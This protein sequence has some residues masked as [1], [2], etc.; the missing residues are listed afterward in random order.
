MERAVLLG[1][2]PILQLLAIALAYYAVWLGYQRA[3][4]L[5]FG[6]LDRFQRDRHA[7]V[8]SLALFLLLGGAAAG[9]LMVDRYLRQPI[10]HGLHGQAAMTAI[11]FLFFG[12]FTG[13]Y[14]YQNPARRT[15]LPLLHAINNL[16]LLLFA[17]LQI[18]TGIR[19][20]LRLLSG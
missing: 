12:L 17:L 10:L 5:H 16:T 6:R 13:L 2:H 11:P 18:Y 7:V 19:F 9:L 15:I 1:I 3:R 20:Y 4:A 8:G 14:L